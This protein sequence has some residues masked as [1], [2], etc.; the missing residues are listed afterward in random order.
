MEAVAS[1]ATA[2]LRA[3]LDDAEV[4]AAMGDSERQLL[5]LGPRSAGVLPSHSSE[6]R[7]G[8]LR[9][10]HQ[11]R[12]SPLVHHRR[13]RPPLERRG[14]A[15]QSARRADG[16]RLRAGPR[17]REAGRPARTHGRRSDRALS[18]GRSA[19]EDRQARLELA[20]R[21]VEPAAPHSA[22]SR[23]LYPLR[24]HPRRHRQGR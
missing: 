22:A 13:P 3:L 8:L 6:R 21:P 12:R 7:E 19:D 24:S 10:V 2:P 1:V 23:R 20:L 15:G 11:Q 14:G 16:G 18:L 5:I 17:G 9:E 4:E